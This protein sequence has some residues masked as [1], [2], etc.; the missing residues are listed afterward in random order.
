[1]AHPNSPDPDEDTPQQPAD[2]QQQQLNKLDVAKNDIEMDQD[3]AKAVS[4]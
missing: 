2:E 4:I 1:M 3:K